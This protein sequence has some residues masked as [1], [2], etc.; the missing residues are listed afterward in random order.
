M[1][2]IFCLE[3]RRTLGGITDY[4]PPPVYPWGIP[5]QYPSEYMSRSAPS[6]VEVSEPASPVF[7]PKYPFPFW[8]QLAPS[9]VEVPEGVWHEKPP[10]TDSG[11]ASAFNAEHPTWSQSKAGSPAYQEPLDE[12]D[13]R[14]AYTSATTTVPEDARKCINDIC[15][16]IST[17]IGR[18]LSDDARAAVSDSLPEL[19]KAFAVMLGS[20]ATTEL[21]RR[22]MRF[23]YKRHK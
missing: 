8:E 15:R 19:V 5:P 6:P 11:Y 4:A 9:P 22:I 10:P 20:L 14:T 1:K 7:P 16:D 18:Q 13:R 12:D 21:E 23:L 3:D 17:K 2:G